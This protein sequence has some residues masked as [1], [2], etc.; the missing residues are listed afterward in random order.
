MD[1]NVGKRIRRL[2]S[3][4]EAWLWDMKSCRSEMKEMRVC[5]TSPL[6]DL[7]RQGREKRAD[8]TESAPPLSVYY[9]P[10]SHSSFTKL[11]P[12]ALPAKALSVSDSE[13]SYRDGADDRKRLS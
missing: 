7:M 12:T 10:S 6:A 2:K 9:P 5:S 13:E 3:V 8:V 1:L 11:I 4:E